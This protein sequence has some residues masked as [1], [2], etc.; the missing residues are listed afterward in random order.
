MTRITC[1]RDPSPSHWRRILL[2]GPQPFMP[3][4]KAVIA[5]SS[6]VGTRG[7]CSLPAP[8]L[9]AESS[10][11]A[12][13]DTC[14]KA[15]RG[16]TKQGGS[17]VGKGKRVVK[18][19]LKQ[20]CFGQPLFEK[21]FKCL[22]AM[23]MV[24]SPKGFQQ[25]FLVDSGAR[26]LISTKDM[27]SQ[28]TDYISDAPEQLKFATGGGMRPSSKAIKLKGELSG[29]GIFYTLKDCPAALSLGQQ[30]NEQG[31]TWVWFPNQLPFFI[32]SHRLSDVT[33]H[34][35]ESAKIYVDRVEQN[36]PILSES[37]ECLAM[38]A[39]ASG[40]SESVMPTGVEPS[41]SEVK[42]FPAPPAVDRPADV[43][44]ETSGE[45]VKADESDYEPSIRADSQGSKVDDV[46]IPDDPVSSE[47]ESEEVAKT[48]NHALTH[49]PK[50][51]HCEIC[52]RAKMT[53]RYHRKRGDP[54]PE[55]TPPSHFGHM[56]RVDHVVM[57]S[58]LSKGSEGEQA[59][60]IC[61]DEYSGCYQAF[62][63]TSTAIDNNVACLRKFGGPKV[64][65]VHCAQ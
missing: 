60:L 57:G 46:G 31:K 35:P 33:F 14:R 27:P 8:H 39:E 45:L 38:P 32:Q 10:G 29:E 23:A 3:E 12:V 43:P 63:Q 65:A 17:A 36:V 52:M 4:S 18:G 30:V 61:F 19:A 62:A 54:D 13:V 40:Q 53:S 42:P 2:Q 9:E 59:C 37:V 5:A 41:S 55:K 24:C 26:N 7:V 22:A 1:T 25:E 11:N 47:D 6:V 56:L 48:L 64:T 58:D 16:L 34:C 28:W 44:E 20:K 49:Y 15:W 50:S 21:A 51:K